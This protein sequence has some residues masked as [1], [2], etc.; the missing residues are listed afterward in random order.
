MSL[1]PTDLLW[2][3]PLGAPPRWQVNSLYQKYLFRGCQA[4]QSLPC[5]G[6]GPGE[7][8][9]LPPP[10]APAKMM[11]SRGQQGQPR[12]C[13]TCPS[14]MML[15]SL[16]QG[17]GQHCCLVLALTATSQPHQRWEGN[18]GWPEQDFQPRGLLPSLELGGLRHFCWLSATE[19]IIWDLSMHTS[20]LEMGLTST[21]GLMT[22]LHG[23]YERFVV[24]L[25]GWGEDGWIQAASRLGGYQ[26]PPMAPALPKEELLPP[27]L[28]ATSSLTKHLDVL[29]LNR[30][31]S[32]AH[33][34]RPLSSWK[35]VFSWP[36]LSGSKGSTTRRKNTFPYSF[37][38]VV[39]DSLFPYG[40]VISSHGHQLW[41]QICLDRDEENTA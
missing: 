25:C 34:N 20:I 17:W 8:S 18:L 41:K 37:S 9:A 19:L 7:D 26:R 27:A 24:S 16:C 23:V 2:K 5:K 33:I 14:V 32:C 13:A 36:A 15:I 28:P 38:D 22:T 40:N 11:L 39:Q 1:S 35:A 6:G 12:A 3:F 31:I 4:H 21:F 30:E 29:S 10:V